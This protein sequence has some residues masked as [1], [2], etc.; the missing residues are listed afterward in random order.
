M[1]SNEEKKSLKDCDT[2]FICLEDMMSEES[3][4]DYRKSYQT[5]KNLIENQQK[6][7]EELK[8]KVREH[9][10]IEA[11]KQVKQLYISKD[12]I[13]PIQIIDLDGKI[14]NV[15]KVKEE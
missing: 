13:K 14:H 11:H 5:L 7:I 9:I 10:C 8:Y 2:I 3:A 1:L 6:E 12:K 4:N 15:Y